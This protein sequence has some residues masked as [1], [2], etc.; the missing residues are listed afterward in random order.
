MPPAAATLALLSA[1]T[2]PAARIAKRQTS[3]QGATAFC[4][5][6]CALLLC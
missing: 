6:A 2:I 1:F 3:Q 4:Q 5:A